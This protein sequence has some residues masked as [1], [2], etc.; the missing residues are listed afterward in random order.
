MS[1][2]PL[3]SGMMDFVKAYAIDGNPEMLAFSIRNAAKDV[4][5]YNQMVE[6]LGTK[7]IMSQGAYQALISAIDEGMGDKL[8][9]EMVDFFAKRAGG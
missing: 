1:A 2:G 9:P 4:G 8:V 6:G 7:S 3:H 5:Y